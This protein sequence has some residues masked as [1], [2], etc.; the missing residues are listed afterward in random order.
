MVADIEA[1]VEGI[2]PWKNAM[3]SKLAELN[4]T[5]RLTTEQG[6]LLIERETKK[7]LMLTSHKRNTPTPS[8]PGSPPS[9][10]SGFLA[11]T[12]DMRGPVPDG[13][14][15]WTASTGPSAVYARIQE[16]GGYV[17]WGARSNSPFGP[18]Q[19]GQYIHIPARPYF[20]PTVVA[21]MPRI[22][23]AYERAWRKVLSA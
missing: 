15:S 17:H 18:Q 6:A 12:W 13:P 14:F 16:L 3:R 1:R 9:M 23:R 2:P 10:I 20:E 21:T 11:R 5:T 19:L 7:T 4:A 8:P 22:Y